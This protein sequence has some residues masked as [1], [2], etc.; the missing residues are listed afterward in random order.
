MDGCHSGK[1]DCPMNC[2][3]CLKGICLECLRSSGYGYLD[4]YNN[5]CKLICGDGIKTIEEDCDD[6]NTAPYD[7]CYLCKY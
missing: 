5:I 3:I 6:G 1:Y 2:S 7:G 4:K